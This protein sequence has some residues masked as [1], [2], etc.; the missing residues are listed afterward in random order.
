MK[1]TWVQLP[2][3]TPGDLHCIICQTSAAFC[4]CSTEN[5]LPQMTLDLKIVCGGATGADQGGL[6]AARLLGLET[7]GW[8]TRGWRTETGPAP[9]LADFGLIEAAGS[10]YAGRT[11][12]NIIDSDVT[13]IFGDTN[14]P[15]SRLTLRTCESTPRPVLALSYMR[16]EEDAVYQ[17]RNFLWANA[18]DSQA[19]WSEYGSPMIVNIAGNRES[20]AP[21]I[22]DYVTSILV[23]ALNWLAWG[24]GVK[25]ERDGE[26]V[27]CTCK[28]QAFFPHSVD[29]ELFI[30]SCGQR[31]Q[32]K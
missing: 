11:K 15:G 10:D 19:Y 16:P 30:C 2:W 26:L 7:G 25:V 18:L 22:Q 29:P 6:Y 32:I 5:Y 13:I 31:Y 27:S 4:S 1:S 17:I 3:S 21:G 28:Q 14:S 23:E 24:E 12:R 8:A 9:W 20:V